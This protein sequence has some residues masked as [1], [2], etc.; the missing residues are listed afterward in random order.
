MKKMAFIFYTLFCM[1]LG[2][3]FFNGMSQ[4]GGYFSNEYYSAKEY[5][6]QSGYKALLGVSLKQNK[7]RTDVIFDWKSDHNFVMWVK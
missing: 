4:A 5:A 2:G 3:F 6:P 1:V 7:K